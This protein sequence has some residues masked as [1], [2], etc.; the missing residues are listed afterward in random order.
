MI[1]TRIVKSKY[2]YN[3][4]FW[5]IF[6]FMQIPLLYDIIWL[7]SNYTV[8]ITVLILDKFKFSKISV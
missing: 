7:A 1:F 2:E 5:I 8:L 6:F 3:A 4:V